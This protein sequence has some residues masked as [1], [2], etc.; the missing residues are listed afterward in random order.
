MSKPGGPRGP[1]QNERAPE[2]PEPDAGR[3]SPGRRAASQLTVRE[4]EIAV[5]TI[6]STYHTVQYDAYRGTVSIDRMVNTAQASLQ[7]VATCMTVP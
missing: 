1:C 5:L 3:R 6:H 7:Y 4:R 2:A